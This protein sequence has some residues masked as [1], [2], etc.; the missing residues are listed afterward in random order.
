[1]KT[2]ATSTTNPYRLFYDDV[3]ENVL[4]ELR[5]RLGVEKVPITDLQREIA[6]L[7]KESDR[8]EEYRK[9]AEEIRQ[10]LPADAIQER[11]NHQD[12]SLPTY[13]IRRIL[14]LDKEG[15]R[16]TKDTL[17]ALG[18]A[19]FASRVH[20]HIVE[21][22]VSYPVK[23]EH[24]TH[25]M[26]D[27]RYI[28]YQFLECSK[29]QLAGIPDPVEVDGSATYVQTGESQQETVV[30]GDSHLEADVLPTRSEKDTKQKQHSIFNYFGNK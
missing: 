25:V 22:D 18:K 28:M 7:W 4:V 16:I 24:I 17:R 5:G 11:K 12:G 2:K 8:Q 1:M 26:S 23:P 6:R 15:P 27:P 30:M 14:D 20:K 9:R 19:T 13:R 21:Q 10:S 3:V 29:E